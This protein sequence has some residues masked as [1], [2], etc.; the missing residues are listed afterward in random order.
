LRKISVFSTDL[1]GTILGDEP[2]TLRFTDT[3]GSLNPNERPL[4]CYNSGRLLDDILQLIY[5][6]EL[7]VPDFI[8]SGVGTSVYD[9]ASERVLKEFTEI[10]E[11]GWDLERV[12]QLMNQLSFTPIKQPQH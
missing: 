4:L 6:G 2:S 5:R 11:D 12:E 1:D 7:P 3:W 8:I 9:F 10:L